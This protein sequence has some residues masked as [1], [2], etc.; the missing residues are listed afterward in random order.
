MRVS[1]HSQEMRAKTKK[2]PPD[3]SQTPE[4]HVGASAKRQSAPEVWIEQL[5]LRLPETRQAKGDGY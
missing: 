5:D 2:K 1:S 3:R 4:K